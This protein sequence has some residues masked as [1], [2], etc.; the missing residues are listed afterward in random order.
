[1]QPLDGILDARTCV[2][3]MDISVLPLYPHSH[4]LSHRIIVMT[5]TSGQDIG[6]PSFSP[7][8][9]VFAHPTFIGEKYLHRVYL[10]LVRNSG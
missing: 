6:S 4:K 9:Y 3:V 5:L 1:M 8:L 10:L 7:A 2:K